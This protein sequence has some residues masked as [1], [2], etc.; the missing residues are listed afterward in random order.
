MSTVNACAKCGACSVVCPVYRVTGREPHT[1]R[2]KIHLA[3][4]A[5][6]PAKGTV[7][8]DI[9]S[10]CLL[11]GAC[12]AVCPRGIDVCRAVVD[13]RGAF[14]AVYGTHGYEKYLTRKALA[15]PETLAAL[16]V[17]GRAGA[18]FLSRYLPEDSGLRL[19]L[20]LFQQDV[21]GM[22]ALPVQK[23]ASPADPRPKEVLT[24]FPGCTARY[25]FPE[26]GLSCHALIAGLGYALH[27]PDGLS[28]CGLA[29]LSAGDRHEARS[30]ARK[31]IGALEQSSGPILVSCASCYAHLL[32]YVDMF[33]DDEPWRLKAEAV[34]ARLVELSCFLDAHPQPGIADQLAGKKKVR[35][36]YHD[37]CHFRHGLKG[38]RIIE[39]PRRVLGRNPDL[40]LLALPGGPGCCGQGGLFHVGAPEISA[41]IRDRLAARVLALNPGVITST[42]SGCLMQWRLA[43][44]HA[45]SRVRVLHLA[46]LLGAVT[47]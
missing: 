30:C 25:L 20:A 45:G 35:V 13:A 42:C 6:L 40:E 2:G 36:Y 31:N 27:V 7:F 23:K 28:C 17:L 26:I 21:G 1:A 24:Y 15:H 34:G 39:E 22:P 14:P 16:R 9:F 47:K 38:Q 41:I 4:I 33:A 46:E 5:E 37:P 12:S 18:E 32:G 29:A 3:S 19:R 43:V 8:E 11:C 10:K 44:E